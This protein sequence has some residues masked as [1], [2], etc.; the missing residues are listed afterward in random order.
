MEAQMSTVRFLPANRMTPGGFENLLKPF[1][2][3]SPLE[4]RELIAV[5]FH[6][7]E[8]G[9]SSFVSPAMM[10]MVIDSLKLPFRRTYM[11]D[12]TVLYGGRRMTAPDYT[13]LAGEHGFGMPDF[14]PFIVA[15]GLT[16]T[17]E[18]RIELPEL[19]T[20]RV[21]RVAGAL[22]RTGKAVVVSHFKGHLLAGFGGAVKHLGM[23]W[24]S[25]AGKL[26]QHS[27]VTPSVKEKKC[28]AC[29]DCIQVCGSDAIAMHQ[30]S[31]LISREQ[32]TGCGECLQA[33]P[34]QAIGIR[35]DQEADTFMR[36]MTEYALGAS[37]AV[38]IPLYV[39]FVTKVSP[40]CDCM[41]N[42][43]PPMVN[44][45]G[46]AVSSDPVALDQACLNMVTA[47]EPIGDN[48]PAGRDKF[49]HKRPERNGELQLE[50]GEAIGLGS[51]EFK[52]TEVT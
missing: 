24:A 23:G 44:D 32:C 46:V 33:C 6:P 19:C 30:S 13:I 27:T 38:D 35:W 10:K 1:T 14:P 18:Y 26:Y 34:V 8:E 39:N 50:I 16:G 4:S 9:N 21:A 36:R 12:T 49:R 2:P 48:A 11:T 47:A 25:K 20:T 37:M 31:A 40:D 29:G 28:I 52:L 17:E 15:D 7:G 51:R 3:I 45:I 41:K 42:E 5:K 43:G 22:S